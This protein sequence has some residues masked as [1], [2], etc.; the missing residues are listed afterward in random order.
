M[1]ALKSGA[2]PTPKQIKKHADMLGLKTKSI[3]TDEEMDTFA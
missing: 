3:P 2:D 1:P